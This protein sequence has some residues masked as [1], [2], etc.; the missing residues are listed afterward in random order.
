MW[1]EVAVVY[2]GIPEKVD[3][4]HDICQITWPPGLE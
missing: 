3:E 4:N 1:K 2:I